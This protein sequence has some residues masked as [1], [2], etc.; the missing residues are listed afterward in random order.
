MK[1]ALSLFLSVVMLFSMTAGIDFSAY[2]TSYSG[3]CGD[4]ATWS[5]DSSAKELTISGSGEM[6]DYYTTWDSDALIYRDPAPW[7][8]YKKTILSVRIGDSI[9]RIGKSNFMWC[10][11]LKN[12]VFGN[13]IDTIGKNAF[14]ACKNLES[15]SLPNNLRIIENCAFMFNNLKSV[16]IPSKVEQIGFSA[17]SGNYKLSE[18]VFPSDT[19]IKMLGSKIFDS[20][21][22]EYNVDE[23][24]GKYLGPYLFKFEGTTEDIGTYNVK[25]GTIG[26]AS[27]AFNEDY[28]LNGAGDSNSVKYI[29]RVNLPNT[30][31]Y[32]GYAAFYYCPNLNN[33][34]FPE[35]VENIWEAPFYDCDSLTNVTIK[36]PLCDIF[37]KSIDGNW[38]EFEHDITIYGYSGS[39]AEAWCKFY[40]P[41]CTF[42]SIGNYDCNHNLIYSYKYSPTCTETGCSI[43]ECEFCHFR[44]ERDIVNAKGHTYKTY[45]TKATTSKNGSIVTK[46]SVCGNVKSKSTIYYPKTVTLSVTSYTY[47][48]KVKKPTVKV[49][50]PNGKTI[51]ASNYTVSYSSGRK[52]VGKYNVK[53]TFK[54][55]YSG[56]ITKTFTIKPKNTS[57]SSVTAKSKGFTV[58]WKKQST[59]TT[60]YQIQYSTSSKFSNAK[61]VTVS[62]NST[63]SKT[64]SKLKAKKKYY[65]RIRTYKT[66][67][68]TKYYSSWSKAKTVTTKK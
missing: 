17:F 57:I 41:G 67:N 31:K 26:I 10:E 59:Q 4:S 52:N 30:L 12:V 40:S 5:Y 8:A 9:T 18:A 32:I 24:G 61:T 27:L 37:S 63:T 46:C 64:V 29:K 65:V 28:R 49:V 44:F 34:V 36:N 51:S 53:I 11:N 14:Y 3:K 55:N 21:S 35:S 22:M 33:V 15:I 7:D 16:Y 25:E 54:G 38:A 39:T 13:N 42:K 66:V 48:G 6:Y 62:K 19:N 56:T 50:D 47:D 2:A 68:G 1:K 58:K 45:T 60:G 43:Y 20:T 23:Y